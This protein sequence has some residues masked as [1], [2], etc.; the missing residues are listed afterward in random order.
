ME[1]IVILLSVGIISFAGFVLWQDRTYELHKQR[2]I[3]DELEEI[4]HNKNK[5]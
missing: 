1:L 5:S 4:F 3:D 2:D